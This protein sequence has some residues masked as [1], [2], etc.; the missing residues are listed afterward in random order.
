MINSIYYLWRREALRS[1]CEKIAFQHCVILHYQYKR[2][3]H[4]RWAKTSKTLVFIGEN[5]ANMRQAYEPLNM[6]LRAWAAD[7][8]SR[9]CRTFGIK[10]STL[11]DAL[12]RICWSAGARIQES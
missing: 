12:A 7:P 11:N 1:V 6:T 5:G 2:L 9:P 10:P 4:Q 3:T 8:N